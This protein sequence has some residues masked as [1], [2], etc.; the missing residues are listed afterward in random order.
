MTEVIVNLS[1]IQRIARIFAGSCKTQK[2][3]YLLENRI[4][5][6]ARKT[7]NAIGTIWNDPFEHVYD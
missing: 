5:Y 4:L 6:D 2:I 7:I 1:P 3:N